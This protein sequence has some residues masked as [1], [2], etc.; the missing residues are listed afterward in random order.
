MVYEANSPK[1]NCQSHILS[2]LYIRVPYLTPFAQVV[3]AVV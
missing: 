2:I 1:V 3:V